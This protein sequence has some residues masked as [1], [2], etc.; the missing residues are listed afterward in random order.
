MTEEE[1][2]AKAAAD[3]EAKAAADAAAA[4]EAAKA[5]EKLGEGGIKAL[6]AEREARE[7]AEKRAAEAEA[8]IQA[9][10]DAKLSD[11]QRAQKERDDQAAENAKLKATNARLSAL[12]THPVPE[13][14]RDLVTGTDEASFLA[15]AKKISELYARAEGKPLKGSPV[16]D[17]GNRNGDTNPAGGSLAAGQALYESRK[18]K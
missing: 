5:D 14:Y 1:I 10:E 2:A 15:S 8:K 3:A 7:A 11:I 4:A 13:E 17:S 12:A 18:K 6:K 9:A 16:H